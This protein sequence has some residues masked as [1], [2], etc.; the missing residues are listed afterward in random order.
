MNNEI[1]IKN[2]FTYLNSKRGKTEFVF[3]RYQFFHYVKMDLIEGRTFSIELH[4]YKVSK[5]TKR[6]N[7]S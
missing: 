4:I 3:E 1:M 7:N 2:K 5:E 6:E